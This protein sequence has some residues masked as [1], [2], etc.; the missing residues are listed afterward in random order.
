M[1]KA[2]IEDG[3]Y[4]CLAAIRGASPAAVRAALGAGGAIDSLQGVELLTAAEARFGVRIADAE[5]TPQV[6]RSVPRMADLV[7]AKCGP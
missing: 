6:C 3:L 5:L 1:T 4:E 2:A 7:A